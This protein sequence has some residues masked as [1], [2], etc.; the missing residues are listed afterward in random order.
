[1][2]THQV[3]VASGALLTTRQHLQGPVAPEAGFG[4]FWQKEQQQ[5]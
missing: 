1:L 2:P 5:R 4:P 3:E